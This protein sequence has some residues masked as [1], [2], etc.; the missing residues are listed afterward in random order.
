MDINT[1]NQELKNLRQRVADLEKNRE[2]DKL[3]IKKQKALM[4]VITKI[5]TPLDLPTI[6]NTTVQEVRQLINAD[7]VA[8]FKFYPDSNWNYGEFVSEDFLPELPSVLYAQVH[9]HC[10]G[11]QYA[12]NYQKG[13]FQAVA[14]IYNADLSPCHIKILSQFQVRANLVLPLLQGQHLWGLLCV[15]QCKQTRIWQQQEIEFI[16]QVAEHLAIAIYQGELLIKTQKKLEEIELTQHQLKT[17]EQKLSLLVNKSPLAVIEWNRNFEVTDWNEAASEMFGYSKSEAIGRHAAGLIIPESAKEELNKIVA[18]LLQE[19]VGNY[20]INDNFTKDGKIIKCEW[21]NTP[22]IVEN[23]VIGVVSMAKDVTERQENEYSLQQEKFKLEIQVQERT[24]QLQH[25]VSQLQQEIRDRTTVETELRALFGAMTDVVIVLDKNGRY[26]KIAPTNPSLLYKPSQELIGKTLAEI[27]PENQAHLFLSYINFSLE[28]KHPVNLEYNLPIGDRLIWF[29]ASISPLSEDQVIWIARDITDCK[30]AQQQLQDSQKFLNN[31]INS[32]SDPIY[33]K[34]KYHKW[35][36][37]NDAFCDLVGYKNHELIGKSDY[38]FFP[39]EQ[40]DILCKKDQ[41]VLITG[42][43]NIHEDI[44]PDARGN[45][46]YISTKKTCFQDASGQKFLVATSRDITDLKQIEEALR[47]SESNLQEAQ[48]MAHVGSWEFNIITQEIAWSNESFRIFG[49][50]PEGEEPSYTELQKLIHQDDLKLWNHYVLEIGIKQGKTYEFEFRC[51]HPQGKIR[52]IWAKG[53]PETNSNGEV[54]KLFG[55]VLDITDRKQSEL[56]LQQA[57]ANLEN[58]VKERT[59]Q[60]QSTIGQLQKQIKERQQAEQK[61]QEQAEFL[62]SIWDGV[63]YGIFVL[64]VIDKGADFR[65]T[66]FNPAMSKTSP[67]PVE[68]L[69]GKTMTEVLPDNVAEPYRQNYIKCI[70]SGKSISFEEAFNMNGKETW[71]M[72]RVNP[73]KDNNSQIDRL[74]VTAT[75]ITARKLAES[76]LSASESKYRNLVDTSQDLIWSVDINGIF[77]FVNPAARYIYGYET[78][79]MLGRSFADFEPLEIQ[80]KD[81]ETFS[82]VLAGES[83][84]QYETIHIAKNG[85]PLNLIFSAVGLRDADGNINGATGTASNITDRKQAEFALRQSEAELRQKALDLENTL[86]ELKRTQT[87]LIQSEKM[88]SLGQLVAGVAHEINNPVNFIYG[89]IE[90]ANEYIQDLLNLIE[91]YQNHYTEPVEE[92]VEQIE[93][94]DLEF[95]LEDLPKLLSSMKL[96]ADRIQKIVASLRTFSRMDEAE[97]KAVNIHEGI[98]ST[99][100]ILQHRLKAKPDRPAIEIIKNYGNLPL[101]ECYAGQLNQVFMNILSNAIDAL[102]E[103]DELRSREEKH[104]M[105]SYIRIKTEILEPD[106]VIIRIADNGAGITENVRQRLFDPFFTTKAVGKGTGMG[107]SISYQIVTQRHGGSLQCISSPGE[108]AEFIIQIPL[109]TC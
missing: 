68:S 80:K 28:T 2:A 39:K 108:G 89:N 10:F 58:R 107:L 57:K 11:S 44:T 62:Q 52:H 86:T 65:Y 93:D 20:S 66:A 60:L 103:R 56:A 47:R 12:I 25:L 97:Q 34:D 18:E 46:R 26:I 87:Q 51:L 38:D 48:K 74:V 79:E 9:D 41:L 15:H 99:L 88:S 19:T 4:N 78:E 84:F 82:K 81:L 96:G 91:L 21:Y 53:Q 16:Q 3:N 45:L 71:W 27:L 6:F 90:H 40:A 104:K 73:L 109:K 24:N 100:L 54:I 43:E 42:I 102:E 30:Q 1:L 31:V 59:A 17:T 105:P 70:Q 8:V 72:M 33:V 63:D 14:D 37:V 75:N 69:L 50:D 92:I 94:I 64:D 83:V 95:L 98:D 61:L 35:V 7:R 101:V 67:I 36:L 55:T 106:Q 77:T 32:T 76:A 85:E 22:L 13:S 23:K 5:R 49:L 29:D